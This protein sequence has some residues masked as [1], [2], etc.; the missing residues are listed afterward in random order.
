MS[1][2]YHTKVTTVEH[3]F[4]IP[5]GTVVA[6]IGLAITWAKKCAEEAGRDTSYDDWAHIE[7]DDEGLHIIVTRKT[8]VASDD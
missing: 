7:T 5:S 4:V 2:V 8:E 3:H 1:S 6:E